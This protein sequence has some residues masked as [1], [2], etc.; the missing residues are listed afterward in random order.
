MTGRFGIGTVGL[1]NSHQRNAGVPVP[2]QVTAGVQ[3]LVKEAGEGA[4]IAKLGI[5]RQAFA[6][7]AAGLPVRRGTLV[8]ALQALQIK[9][10]S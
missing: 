3:A 2:H 6:R 9:A 7:L 1:M 5:S 4:A 8:I 10:A